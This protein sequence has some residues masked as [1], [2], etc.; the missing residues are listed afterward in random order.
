MDPIRSILVHVD[1][2]VQCRARLALAA[3]LGR[4]RGADVT[5]LYA[6][7]PVVVAM[8]F[9]VAMGAPPQTMLDIDESRMT[10]ART[11]VAAVAAESGVPIAWR[12]ARDGP[13]HAT[14]AQA[15]CADLLL[16]GQHD[17]ANRHTGVASDFAPWVIT[18]SGKPAIVVPYIGARAA[19][20]GNVLVAWKATRESSRALS[21]AI[22]FLQSAQSVN[23]AIDG[24]TGSAYREVLLEFLGRHGIRATVTTL[25]SR[26]SGAGEAILSMAADVGADLIVMGCYGHS[27]ARE[28]ALGGASRTVLESMTV[29]VL[30][31]H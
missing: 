18:G 5:A 14:I 10:D 30:M 2:G 20:F 13:E 23:V 24:D 6:V 29:P 3:A 4:A 9:D 31:A 12:E 19:P 17:R 28:F 22:P 27:R 1:A 11:L 25:S 15:L 7:T 8:A 26:T 21:A 16:L